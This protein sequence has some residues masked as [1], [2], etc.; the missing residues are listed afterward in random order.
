V[1]NILEITYLGYPILLIGII[2]FFVKSEYL[3]NLLIF[4]S[5]FTATTIVSF[6]T[7]NLMPAQYFAILLVLRYFL[8]ER[9]FI[10]KKICEP[11]RSLMLF[12]VIALISILANWL[13]STNE[14][15]YGI[16]N[17]VKLTSSK[18]SLRNLTQF[19]Y[20]LL[21]FLVYWMV[22]DYC[23]RNPKYQNKAIVNLM[24]SGV[25]VSLIGFYELLSFI[26]SLP[27]NEIFRPAAVIPF[28]MRV[29]SVM[30]EP[31]FLSG[32][33][34]PLLGVIYIYAI[35]NKKAERY[36]YIIIFSAVF[37][38][39]VI[40]TSTTFFIGLIGLL[41]Y[42]IFYSRKSGSG[43]I[44][45]F[46]IGIVLFVFFIAI[47]QS[48]PDIQRR[49][50]DNNI[51][52]FALKNESG[53]VRLLVSFHMLSVALHHPILGVGFGS[54]R[55]TDLFINV[56]ACTGIVGFLIF[57][58]FIIRLI[59]KLLKYN[60]LKIDNKPY[61]VAYALFLLLFLI[62]GCGV[63]DYPVFLFF[64]IVMGMANAYTSTT[65]LWGK[66]G[67]RGVDA[68]RAGRQEADGPGKETPA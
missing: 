29:S 32:F 3:F 34:L 60:R 11:S 55:S 57:F 6:S 18:V 7:F 25:V 59:V 52:K 68:G 42:I 40:S 1:H 13:L 15:V 64:W 43:K 49:I 27:F 22:N 44:T 21:A 61:P 16:G 51:D 28:Y 39:G 17:G 65:P 62:C 23:S 33:I 8:F 31:S 48:F 9:F 10:K 58:G 30:A 24:V 45:L 35:K 20:L 37:L 63:P 4:F 54:G 12:L 50:V 66:G 2:L 56:L 19:S 46:I 5:P 47:L 14:V 36:V 41:F 67:M 26:Y 38:L 53:A